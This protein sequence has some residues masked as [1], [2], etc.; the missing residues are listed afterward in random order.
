M[1]T[2][3]I[4]LATQLPAARHT[5]QKTAIYAR[6]SSAEHKSNPESQ[7]ERLAAYCA[8]RRYQVAKVVKEIGS[9]A[10]YHRPKLLMPWGSWRT[11]P[12]ACSSWRT[13]TA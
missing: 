3:T 6:V 13:R 2:G 9:G 10:N 8:V 7:A 1:D 4:L 11:R 12:S 5:S